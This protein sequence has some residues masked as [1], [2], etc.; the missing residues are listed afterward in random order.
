MI[1]RRHLFTKNVGYTRTKPD[2]GARSAPGLQRQENEDSVLVRTDRGLWAV[3]D[4]MGGHDAGDVASAMVTDA[5]RGLPIVYGLD[6]LV[7]SATTALQSVTEPS[8]DKLVIPLGASHLDFV[9][10][11]TKTFGHNERLRQ[12]VRSKLIG[13]DRQVLDLHKLSTFPKN[14]W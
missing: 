2:P 1:V 4:G 5:L 8:W 11:D 12:A 14:G 10:K 6:E 9:R 13:L 7:E 3:A